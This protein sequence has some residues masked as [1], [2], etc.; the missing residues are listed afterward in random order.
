MIFWLAAIHYRLATGVSI[1][2]FDQGDSASYIQIVLSTDWSMAER[3]ESLESDFHSPFQID[4]VERMR[5]TLKG[6]PP[7]PVLPQL[8]RLRE[9][10]GQQCQLDLHIAQVQ[11][12]P[13]ASRASLQPFSSALPLPH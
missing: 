8:L 12:Q 9:P 6:P 13:S 2:S 4:A 11:Q 1:S 10:S 3:L 5:H 7:N